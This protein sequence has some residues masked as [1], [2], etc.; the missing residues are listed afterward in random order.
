MADAVRLLARIPGVLASRKSNLTWLEREL[1]ASKA[2]LEKYTGGKRVIDIDDAI[3]L[4]SK[5]PFT[6]EILR[7]SHTV[8][9]GNCY[10]A[11]YYR[12]AGARVTVIPT[13]IDTDLWK[14]M[15]RPGQESWTVGWIGTSSNLPYLYS[16]EEPLADFLNDHSGTRLLVVSNLQPHFRLIPNRAVSFVRWTPHM[17]NRLVQ[18]MDVGIMPLTDTEWELGKCACKM[19]LYMAVGIPCIATPIGSSKEILSQARIGCSAHSLDDWYHSLKN[20][21]RNPNLAFTLG[22]AGRQL[23][24]ERYSV[25][26]NVVKLADTFQAV[27]SS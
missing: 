20:L 10:I 8:I 12:N 9:A 14:P 6:E 18:Q 15:V 16:I 1:I 7:Y 26:K 19:L 11:D 13:S 3:W 17:E 23:V 4:T 5:N 25:E 24:T 21:F 27:L 22:R 2:T